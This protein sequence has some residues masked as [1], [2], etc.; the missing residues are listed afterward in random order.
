MNMT[1]LI[2]PTSIRMDT[3]YEIEFSRFAEEC[4]GLRGRGNICILVRLLS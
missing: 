4:G 3:V 1:I 2:M